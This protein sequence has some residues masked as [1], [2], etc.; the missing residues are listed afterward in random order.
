M[1]L[2]SLPQ[3]LS[4]TANVFAEDCTSLETLPNVLP[5]TRLYLFNCFRLAENQGWTDTFFTMLS[6]YAQVS[7]SLSL[8]LSLY[9]Y[10]YIYF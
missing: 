6:G 7:L 2:R 1:R 8:S 3:L 4:S 5:Q 9:I 10:I